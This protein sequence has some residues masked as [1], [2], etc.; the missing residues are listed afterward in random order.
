MTTFFSDESSPFPNIV[1]IIKGSS[2]PC[3]VRFTTL[4]EGVSTSQLFSNRPNAPDGVA[5]AR[6]AAACS[7]LDTDSPNFIHLAIV[8]AGL[9]AWKVACTAAPYVVDMAKW[10]TRFADS[11]QTS[12]VKT[13]A[14]KG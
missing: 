1:H 14:S 3:R 13:R 10:V 11:Y 12:S 6:T 4:L 9:A 8:A 2:Q 7:V 5:Y